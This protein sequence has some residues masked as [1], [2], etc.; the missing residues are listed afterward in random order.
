MLPLPGSLLARPEG[1]S[2]WVS[3]VPPPLASLSSAGPSVAPWD[4][5]LFCPRCGLP[6]APC[7]RH[8]LGPTVSSHLG[9]WLP[10]R[11][12]KVCTV[13][14]ARGPAQAQV[15]ARD[16]SR[17]PRSK[18]GTGRSESPGRPQASG[19]CWARPQLGALREA[20]VPTPTRGEKCCADSPGAPLRV[21]LCP[22]GPE[23]SGFASSRNQ[24]PKTLLLLKSLNLSLNL[25]IPARLGV[26]SG[27]REAAPAGT[28]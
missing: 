22:G 18:V 14:F 1:C 12:G 17:S 15:C 7:P 27:L 26:N 16:T 8:C 2:L 25:Q 28:L 6:A 4:H 3:M 10:T 20:R 24:P 21:P 19:S 11:A 23:S 5:C 13:S 9:R